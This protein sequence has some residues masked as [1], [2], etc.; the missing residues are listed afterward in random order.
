EIDRLA[1]ENKALRAIL[2][3]D[4][5]NLTESAQLLTELAAAFIVA[6]EAGWST[7]Q[8]AAAENGRV[9]TS[10]PHYYTPPGGHPGAR[11]AYYRLVGSVRNRIDE[12]NTRKDNNW[13]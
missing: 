12:F 3:Y 11:S 6:K 4:A 13:K 5:G 2:G 7:P 1:A 9:A 10:K 8:Q